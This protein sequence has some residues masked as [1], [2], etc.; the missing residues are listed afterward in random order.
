MSYVDDSEFGFSEIKDNEEFY[1]FD[2]IAEDTD[3][4]LYP[5]KFDPEYFEFKCLTQEQVM[6]YPHIC[7]Y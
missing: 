3:K 5:N 7:E 2:N 6:K 4:D 1:D